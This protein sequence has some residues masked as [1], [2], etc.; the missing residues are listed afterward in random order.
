MFK[1][2]KNLVLFL[3]VAVLTAAVCF[4]FFESKKIGSYLFDYTKK[5]YAKILFTGDLMFDR[6]IR[7]YAGQNG[8]NKFIFNKINY[9]LADN[10][11]VVA[12][13]EGPITENKSKSAGTAPGSANNYYF[14]FDKSVA[15]TLFEE[16][17]KLVSLGN[18]HI[19]NF[20]RDGL[21]QTKKYLEQAHVDYFGA[22]DYPRSIG[23][24]ING[25]KIAFIN[26]N[27]FSDLRDAEIPSALE[28]IKK[29]K[30]YADI[31][32]VFCHWGSEYQLKPA[33]SQKDLGHK[34]IDQG[35]DLVIGAHP[36][37]IQPM[38]EYKGKRIYYSL[39]NFIF[40]Q[41]FDENVRKGMGVQIKIDKKT[42][43]IDFKDINFYL[44][45][46]GQTI[47]K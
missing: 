34:F 21:A 29:A 47:E 24:E 44:Q 22:P 46:N 2:Q 43:K 30:E 36:H 12:N 11:L 1:N 26:Y 40:D 18:N 27:E 39:G 33:N 45:K 7:Y 8:G 38:E 35:A 19:L 23:A 15:K 5:D 10:D 37:V 20:G 32:I 31:I 9:V 13:L 42:N 6:G 41:Y 25:I 17:I 4:T 3:A 14:T 28:E 16:N